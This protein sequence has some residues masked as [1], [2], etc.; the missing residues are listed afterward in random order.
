[1]LFALCSIIIANMTIIRESQLQQYGDSLI[2]KHNSS[3]NQKIVHQ[4]EM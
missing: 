2:Q 3:T 4:S 1:M